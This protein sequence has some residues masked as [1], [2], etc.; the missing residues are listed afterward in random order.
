MLMLFTFF[1]ENLSEE[2]RVETLRDQGLH[3]HLHNWCKYFVIKN[4][5]S[6]DG[7][8]GIKTISPQSSLGTD[9]FP[10][11]TYFGSP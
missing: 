5:K 3:V 10:R 2:V 9:V 6:M 1:G 4:C 8:M 11:E 7:N